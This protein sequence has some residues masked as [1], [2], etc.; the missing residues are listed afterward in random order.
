MSACDNSGPA[1]SWRDLGELPASA[2]TELNHTPM[3]VS[4]DRVLVGTSDGIWARPLDGSGD[5][6]QSGLA[7][8]VVSQRAAIR[9]SRRRYLPPA[10][11]STIRRRRRSTVLTTAA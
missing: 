10:S 9:R 3:V 2:A 1:E 5:W 4:G 6:T 11:R 7:G 8:I